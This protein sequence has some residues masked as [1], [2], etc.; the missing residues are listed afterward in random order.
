MR[1]LVSSSAAQAA[2][3]AAETEFGYPADRLMEEA[4]IRLQDRLETT[5]SPSDLVAYLAGPGN[6]GGDAWVMARHAH[7]R[8]RP[9]VVVAWPPSSPLCR[10]QAEAAQRVGVTVLRWPSTD[11]EAALR[12]CRVW[13]DGL[14]GTGLRGPLRAEARTDLMTLETWRQDA[15]PR[16]I[17]LDVPSGVYEGRSVDEAVLGADQT[18]S[19][20]PLKAACWEP[21]NRP[22]CGSLSDVKLSFPRPAAPHAWLVEPADLA[23]LL[24]PLDAGTHKGRRG[25]VLVVGGAPG[26]TG[27]AVLAARSAAAAG[28]GLVSLAVDADLVG[29]VAP[30]VPAFQ[31]RTH[32]TVTPERYDAVVLGPGWGQG[33]EAL[34]RSWTDTRL[35][36]VLDADALG[37]WTPGRRDGPT[38]LTPHPGEFRRLTGHDASL[39]VAQQWA[40]DYNVVVVLKGASTWV[41]APDR[42]WVWD[43]HEPA[44]AT[45]GSGDCLAGLVGALLASGCPAAEAAVAAVALHGQAGVAGALAR[46]WFTADAL[47]AEVARLSF[48]CRTKSL[49]L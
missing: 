35:P 5:T 8:G 13:V 43:G 47:V 20:G 34:L 46:G 23:A 25:H 18:W 26:M 36:L 4:G 3:R 16:V 32:D 10:A 30:Q 44:L 28:A 9:G 1:G 49:P 6:N 19:A 37:A 40:S 15:G 17:A 12:R 21:A 41:V 14:W 11:A 38:V 42:Q 24:P 7:L 22:A 39:A 29:V 31:V 33:R 27:A 48:A 45:G 2:D